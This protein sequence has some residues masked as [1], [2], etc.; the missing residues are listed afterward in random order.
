[1]P[2]SIDNGA[3]IRSAPSPAR[4][5]ALLPQS[6][7]PGLQI[8]FGRHVLTNNCAEAVEALPIRSQRGGTP[9]AKILPLLEEPLRKRGLAGGLK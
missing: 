6:N 1:M 9:V 2:L 8:R 4:G 5:K 3:R 7:D